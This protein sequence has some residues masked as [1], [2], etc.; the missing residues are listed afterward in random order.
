V[1]AAMS[2]DEKVKKV[3]LMVSFAANIIY[4]SCLWEKSF[5]MHEY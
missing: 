4:A 5:F 2:S 3:F 1:P